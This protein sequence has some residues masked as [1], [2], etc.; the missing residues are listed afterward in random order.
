M[1]FDDFVNWSAENI[2]D[3]LPQSYCDARVIVNKV[4]KLGHSYTGMCVMPE[5]ENIAATVDLDM[6]Y[7]EHL[8][9]AGSRELLEKMAGMVQYKHPE[10]DFEWIADYGK[11]RDR[12]FIRVCGIME[13]R[14]LLLYVPH[15]NLADL[16]ITYHILMDV[17]D[18]CIGSAMITDDMLE[19]YNISEEQLHSDA[20]KSSSRILPA[21]VLPLADI[22]GE[23]RLPGWNLLAVTNENR[24]NG[25]SALFY[26][27]IMEMVAGIVGGSYYVLPSSVHEMLV[28]RDDGEQ[29]V[30]RLEDIVRHINRMDVVPR[31]DFLSDTVYYYDAAKHAFGLAREMQRCN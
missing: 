9:G 28:L 29:D 25:A 17:H 24:I 16:S 19:S 6:F 8:A 2:R 13:N 5:G 1:N 15:K 23:E 11:V 22:L 27:D 21:K 3:F 20:L 30:G 18:G 4:E 31:D 10:A 12:L 7:R 14:E 26:P